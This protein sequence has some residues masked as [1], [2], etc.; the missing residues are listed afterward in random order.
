MR[1]RVKKSY[2]VKRSV[3]KRALLRGIRE[4]V[5]GYLAALPLIALSLTVFDFAGGSFSGS[6][7]FFISSG[8][9]SS[10]SSTA[11]SGTAASGRCATNPSAPWSATFSL[12]KAS[13]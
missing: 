12:P 2:G 6:P 1:Q 8:A 13:R 10:E 4:T 11:F 7:G 3:A 9:A 5:A